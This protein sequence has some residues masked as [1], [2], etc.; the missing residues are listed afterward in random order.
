[1][2][3]LGII[4]GILSVVVLLAVG[5]G[6][7]NKILSNVEALGTNLLTV[8]P[9]GTSQTNVRSTAS[10]SSTNVLTLDESDLIATLPNIK[11]VS[12]EYSSRK[13]VIYGSNNMQ[14]SIYGVSPSY[15]EVRNATVE[16]GAFISKSNVDNVDKVAV[17]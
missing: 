7:T 15:L 9:G 14:A 6:A 3:S 5:Q 12:P 1:M 8:S 16:Y 10:K 4:I 17:I 11:A 13:Q 2:S